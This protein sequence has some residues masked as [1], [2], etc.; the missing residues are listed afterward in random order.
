MTCVSTPGFVISGVL[1]GFAPKR[2][3]YLAVYTSQADFEALRF[4][5]SLRFH[6]DSLPPDSIHFRFADIPAGDYM[7]ASYQDMDEDGAMTR[8]F[9]GMPKEPY[10]IHRPNYGMF[11]PNFERCKFRVDAD[12]TVANIDF[13]EGSK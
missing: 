8:G 9:M 5:R 12:Y 10:R 7:V 6:A 13:G 4:C 1:T 3:L 2:A 11:G